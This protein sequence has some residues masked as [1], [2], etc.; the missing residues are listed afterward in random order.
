MHSILCS[1]RELKGASRLAHLERL[2][3]PR[4]RGQQCQREGGI[5]ARPAQV[6]EKNGNFLG[7]CQENAAT[8]QRKRAKGLEVVTMQGGSAAYEHN[9]ALPELPLYHR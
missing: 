6:A 1:L 4:R 9:A 2:W 8:G 5:S 3:A 7:L